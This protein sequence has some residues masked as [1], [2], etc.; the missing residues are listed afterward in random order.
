M[1][2]LGI[3]G[4]EPGHLFPPPSPPPAQGFEVWNDPVY[5][6]PA[7]STYEVSNGTSITTH[8]YNFFLVMRTFKIYF[9]SNFQIRSTVISTIVATLYI[10]SL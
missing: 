6:V 9:L 7:S 10:T 2:I 3:H 8:S 5:E 1:G 4:Q